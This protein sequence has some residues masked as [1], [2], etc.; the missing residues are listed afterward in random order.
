MSTVDSNLDPAYAETGEEKK[1]KKR[2]KFSLSNP[3]RKKK[4]NS[5]N[6]S[7]LKGG[8][9]KKKI[10]STRLNLPTRVNSRKRKNRRKKKKINSTFKKIRK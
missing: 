7:P 6:V 1:S 3:F 2:K 9:N 8:Y 4:K 5:S 10:H